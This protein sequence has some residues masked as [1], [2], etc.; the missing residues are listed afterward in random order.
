MRGV[1]P[2]RA[3]ITV[4]TVVDTWAPLV[5][6]ACVQ[7]ENSLATFDASTVTAASVE[8]AFGLRALAVAEENNHVLLHECSW[9]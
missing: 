8:R 3:T 9:P 7:A 5:L 2:L 1:A 4:C 6:A